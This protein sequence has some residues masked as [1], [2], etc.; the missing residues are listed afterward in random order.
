[1]R[2]EH[3]LRAQSELL[4]KCRET[5]TRSTPLDTR[6]MG[7]SQTVDLRIIGVDPTH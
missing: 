2:L 1:L 5:F 4:T 3:P 7:T 6:I